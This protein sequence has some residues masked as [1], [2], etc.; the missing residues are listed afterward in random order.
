MIGVEHGGGESVRPERGDERVRVSDLELL[1]GAG[2]TRSVF[3]GGAS[4]T[5][6]IGLRASAP[7][8]AGRLRLEF[9]ALDGTLLFATASP[10][11]LADERP[12]ILDYEIGDLALLG[13]DYELVIAL[14]EGDG[15]LHRRRSAR[16]ALARDTDPAGPEGLI[17]LRGAWR[18]GAE[19]VGLGGAPARGAMP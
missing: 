10:L 14:D 2:R 7:L 9:H 18:I 4:M 16:F 6:R 11:A 19:P 1:D 13:G 8:A 17:D 12:A 15:V 3:A 5:V